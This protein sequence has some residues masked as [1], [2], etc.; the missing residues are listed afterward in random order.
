MKFMLIKLY[1]VVSF[2]ALPLIRLYFILR[3]S[4]Q[5]E[6]SQRYK[7]KFGQWTLSRPQ[8]K[9]F[10]IH[11]ASV[12]EFLAILPLLKEAETKWP[13]VKFLVTTVTVT[14]AQIFAKQNLA[15]CIHQFAPVD[16]Y[17]IARKFFTYW[18]PDLAI[19]TESELW[20][21]L[22]LTAKKFC[23]TVL[24][25]A[26]L[27]DKSYH[28]WQKLLPVVKAMVKSFDLIIASSE[29]DKN[30]YAQLGGKNIHNF[31]NIKEAALPLPANEEL[32]AELQ[33]ACKGRVL[34]LASS[35]HG[36]EEEI[37]LAAHKELHLKYPSLLTIIAPRHP[38]RGDEIQALCHKNNLISSLRSLSEEINSQTDVY[39]ANTIGEL[40]ILYRLADIVYV[41][42][43]LVKHGGQNIMEPA[44]LDCALITGPH[45]F[46]FIEN[47]AALKAANAIIEV[48]NQQELVEA[49]SLL[50]TNKSI[51]NEMQLKAKQVT[52]S[53]REM[54]NSAIKLL[55]DTYKSQYRLSE[56]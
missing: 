51:R 24:L 33:L 7:E 37:I 36:G 53:K 25:N 50:L 15:N 49:V 32:L 34:W 26:R 38:A 14:S 31:G 1:Q 35:T 21:N 16:S 18:H 8:G 17:Y 4:K 3:L 44:R 47:I 56:S 22:V 2:F 28:L 46:N 40:G 48:Q 42:G 43:S 41:G 27:S 6:N 9:L 19:F 23:P 52:Y 39:I 13:E 11:A 45:T 54:L 20:P 55:E 12:G 10:W 30:K 29:L 5:K